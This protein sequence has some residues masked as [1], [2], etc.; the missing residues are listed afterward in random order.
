MSEF[1]QE[2]SITTI[3]GFYDLFD[4]E[5]YLV[6]LERKLEKFSRHMCIS[7][8]LPCLY[9]EIHVPGVLDNIVDQINQVNY[10][11]SVVV[12]LGGAKEERE[13][14]EAKEF[15]LKLKKEDRDVKVVWVEGPSIGK[16]F[17]KLEE[18][19]IPVGVRGK[20]QSVWITL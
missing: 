9:D 5:E 8:L 16:I 14:K 12:A 20:G 19:K 11:C 2:G 18:Q 7:L 17:Q 3:H 1:H 4:P 10:V 13:F 15:F 6:R